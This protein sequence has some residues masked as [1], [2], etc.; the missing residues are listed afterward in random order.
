MLKINYFIILLYFFICISHTLQGEGM[1]GLH[2]VNQTNHT[3]RLRMST[4]ERE[5]AQDLAPNQSYFHSYHPTNL[6][7]YSPEGT[8]SRFYNIGMNP[9][10]FS[11]LLIRNQRNTRG[12]FVIG[13]VGRTRQRSP[14]P[15]PAV[16]FDPNACLANCWNTTTGAVN[17]ERTNGIVTGLYTQP[18]PIINAGTDKAFPN[19]SST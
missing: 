1:Q 6:T 9:S 4:V 8:C 3:V 5:Y 18:T 17:V 10:I 7:L 15:I 19:P 12:C 13:Y 2:I 14:R 11:H 16:Q